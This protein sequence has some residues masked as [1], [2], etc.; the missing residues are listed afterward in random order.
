MTFLET[1]VNINK[2]VQ[3][4]DTV[5][6]QQPVAVSSLS[7]PCPASMKKL[8]P[9]R[10]GSLSGAAIFVSGR[11]RVRDLSSSLIRI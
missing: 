10:P 3:H 2:S 7:C 1:E 8:S 6:A 5:S 4:V 11:V 9:L